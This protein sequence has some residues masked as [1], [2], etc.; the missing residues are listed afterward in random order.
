MTD[1]PQSELRFEKGCPDCARRE[2]D[3]PD[4]LPTLGDDFD[5]AVRDYDG[6]RMFMMEELAARFPDRSRWTPA[7]MEVVIVEVLAATLDQ[8]SDT[9][10]RITLE[11]YLETARRP[12]SVR[13]LLKL[14]GYDAVALAWD[15][16]E[17][18]DTTGMTPQEIELAKTRSLERSW[19]ERPQLM[20]WA[21]QAG[22]PSLHTQHRMVTL[23]DYAFRLEA[24]PL[25]LRAHAWA[26]WGGSWN[27][28]HVAVIGWDN[29]QLDDSIGDLLYGPPG[30]ELFTDLGREV[31]RFHTQRTRDGLPD[32]AATD[33]TLRTLLHRFVDAYR[34]AGQ[35]VIL[36]DIQPIGI[37]MAFSITVRP[38]FFQSEVRRAVEQVLGRGPQG[39]FRPG[40]LSFG[41]DLHASDVVQA[42]MKV[43]GVENVCLNR[44]KR[45][46]GGFPDQSTSGHIILSGLQIAVCDNDAAHPERG[47]YTM[48]LYGGRKG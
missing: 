35:E 26:Q 32:E 20:E 6:F 28:V 7:D 16:L 40:R 45:V 22:P 13:R 10:D 3:L 41:E 11:G 12:E 17:P 34:M 14:I 36:Q 43:E 30:E 5:W 25:V 42:V 1:T 47:Y 21:R 27:V 4:P 2:A 37:S 18:Q 38:E 48:K 15:K 8:L 31:Q 19:R 23:E 29:R 33:I 46:G 24:H 9:L 39:F 44:F